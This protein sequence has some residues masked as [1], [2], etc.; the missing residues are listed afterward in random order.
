MRG[1]LGDGD[2]GHGVEEPL[3]GRQLG[4]AERPH[5]GH[6]G[7][8]QGTEEGPAEP[9]GLGGHRQE[10][11]PP[12]SGIALPA[13]MAEALQPVEERRSPG[14]VEAE[15]LAQP[16]G[17]GPVPGARRVQQLDQG[18]EVG[19]VQAAESKAH[20]IRRVR[21]NAERL[22]PHVSVVV[23]PGTSHH[24]LPAASP[25]RLNQELTAFLGLAEASPAERPAIGGG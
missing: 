13:D 7:V 10:D 25:D 2:V 14:R 20:D 18:P 6:G 24:F 22:L 23:L 16:A 5:P 11:L 9:L 8:D 19:R 17:G 12:V 3:D 1:S 21:A 15:L 4:V